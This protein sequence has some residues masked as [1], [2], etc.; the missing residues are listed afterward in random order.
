MRR[1]L[2]IAGQDVATYFKRRKL[3]CGALAYMA[4]V[5]LGLNARYTPLMWLLGGGAFGMVG[6]I[7]F[8]GFT[9]GK[10]ASRFFLLVGIFG[11]G[12]AWCSM[13][14]ALPEAFPGTGTYE[15]S[16]RVRTPVL[17][18]D[19]GAARFDVSN[20]TLSN[21]EG[22]MA[23]AGNSYVWIK[24]ESAK[25]LQP[26]DWIEF[27]ASLR[28]PNAQRNP[29]G[30][31]ARRW[32]FSRGDHYSLL[33]DNP[34]VIIHTDTFS[35]T[36]MMSNIRSSLAERIGGLFG[37]NAPLLR[38]ILLGDTSML[39]GE[40]REAFARTGI[41]HL[42][43]VSG[44]HV[45]FL[46]A[47]LKV[48]LDRLE[49]SP[50]TN[51]VCLT[52]LL[53]F[54][55]LLTGMSVSILRASLMLLSMTFGAVFARQVDGMTSLATAAVLI[56]IFKPLDIASAGFNLTFSALAGMILL[57]PPIKRLF[58]RFKR[59]PRWMRSALS[60]TLAAQLG[61]FIP[62]VQIAGSYPLLSPLVNMAAIPL[63]SLVFP[64]SI[65]VLVVDAV[66][67]P[68][69]VI[70]A[71]PERAALW[72]LRWLADTGAGWGWM[73][74]IPS[75]L[76]A[77]LIIG[78]YISLILWSDVI[79]MKAW[80][81][82]AMSGVIL[83]SGIAVLI[84]V[85]LP[86]RY[87][88]LDVGQEL[89]GVLHA[90]QAVVVIDAGTDGEE[91]VDYLTAMGNDVDA[92]FI[93]HGHTDHFGGLALLLDDP[94]IKTHQIYITNGTG[95]DIDPG[96]EDVLEIARGKGIPVTALS[97]GDSVDIG[98]LAFDVLWPPGG[99]NVKEANETSLVLRS[100]LNGQTILWTGDIGKMEPLSGVRCDIL[101]VGHHGSQYSTSAMFL[102]HSRPMVGI[103]SASGT[104]RY[105][106]HPSTLA[107]LDE[108]GVSVWQTDQSGAVTLFINR[109]TL[110]VKG[111]TSQLG[112]T[113]K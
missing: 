73:V 25:R 104:N 101:V 110:T 106:P 59:L 89:S 100:T 64:L 5:A 98:G 60:A 88:Q 66:Y 17:V 67:H 21:A 35:L 36:R 40:W 62:S 44:L 27:T 32:A 102:E 52:V 96:Y 57:D 11:I 23:L 70:L 47:M 74:R 79:R 10:K 61:V 94:I 33:S 77:I 103:I 53:A 45:G 108:A 63:A 86:I 37:A 38:A 56:L 48:L 20:I 12:L 82:A 15:V 81:R 85:R 65:P 112:G 3:L 51:F 39:P 7:R 92:L 113:A 111:Y 78:W 109:D 84:I 83:A 14:A 76:P 58:E 41:V 43:A 80:M 26:G 49:V 54:Y 95:V 91:L 71:W 2:I 13:K 19:D 18:R 50:M 24:N 42:L 22:T 55:A 30:F 99:Y 1:A 8:A 68:L 87:V 72:L 28:L 16:A 9:R 93:S 31:D 29:G 105:L 46:Y 97:R 75:L 69:A 4:G 6:W 34:V 107:R 90:P